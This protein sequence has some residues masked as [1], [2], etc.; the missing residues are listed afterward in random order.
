MGV[1]ARGR[2]GQVT[3]GDQDSMIRT[4]NALAPGLN[5]LTG[6]P[7]KGVDDTSASLCPADRSTVLLW[8]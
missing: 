2:F 6:G 1:L 5:C 3:S 8:L 7:I 4:Y